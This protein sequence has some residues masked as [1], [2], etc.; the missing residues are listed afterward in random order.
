MNPRI[1]VTKGVLPHPTVK[2]SIALH[3]D[4][5]IPAFWEQLPKRIKALLGGIWFPDCVIASAQEADLHPSESLHIFRGYQVSELG[6][7][8]A[9]VIR[10][11]CAHSRKV[12]Q[13][14]HVNAVK[15][16]A[17]PGMRRVIEICMGPTATEGKIT[18]MADS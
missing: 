3:N 7:V 15:E 8:T 2:M 11:H 1:N 18:T 17:Q 5:T 4:S 10:S 16:L 12:S 14:V 6:L 9:N 13:E